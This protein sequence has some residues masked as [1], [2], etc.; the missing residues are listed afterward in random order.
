[1]TE[2]KYTLDADC[3]NCG[4]VGSVDI[5]K[6]V[7]LEEKECPNCE[8]KELSRTVEMMSFTSEH[9]NFG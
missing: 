3:S 4:F 2:E 6:G 7:K 9:E 8:C 5:P 1:M